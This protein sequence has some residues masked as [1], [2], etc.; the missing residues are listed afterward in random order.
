MRSAIELS[1]LILLSVMLAGC[2]GCLRMEAHWTGYSSQCINGV[3]YYQF[4]SGA[5]VAYEKDGKV[6]VC[7]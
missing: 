3:V 6:V 4:A 5:A 1:F 2:G 7:Q